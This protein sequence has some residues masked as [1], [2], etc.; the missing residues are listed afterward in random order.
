MSTNGK[1][2]EEHRLPS[3][4][5]GYAYAVTMLF[6]QQFEHNLRALVYVTDYHAWGEDMPLDEPQRKRFR[7]FDRFIDQATCG[8]LRDKFKQSKTVLHK[9]AWTAFER[10]CKHRNRLAHSFL[11]EQNF[12]SFTPDDEARLL[13]EIHSMTIDLYRALLMTRS[14]RRQAEHLA[15][16]DHKSLSETMKIL[17]VPDWQNPNRHYATRKKKQS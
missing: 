6:A 1:S 17:G 12:D 5:V 9:D 15:D 13:I 7:S 2:P 16:E 11:A 3:R 4:D 10:A 14:L 8:A